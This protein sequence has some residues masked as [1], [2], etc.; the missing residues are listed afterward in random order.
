M[1]FTSIKKRKGHTVG[2]DPRKITLAITKAGQATGEFGA[3]EAKILTMKTLALAGAMAAGDTIEV[4]ALQDVVE[5]VLLD[6]PFRPTAKAYILY[7]EQRAVMRRLAAKANV[8]LMD[9]Y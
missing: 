1:Q 8:E 3:K 7:R 5:H 6:S 9:G 4:E 2:F